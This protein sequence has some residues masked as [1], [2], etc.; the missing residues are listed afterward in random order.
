VLSGET[1]D[2][3]NDVSNP[4]RVKPEVATVPLRDDSLV[5][6]AHSVCMA[7]FSL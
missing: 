3:F 5:I 6:P 1:P 7:E 2:A 4:A